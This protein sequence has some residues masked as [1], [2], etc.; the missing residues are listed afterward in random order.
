MTIGDLLWQY[1]LCRVPEEGL[2]LEEDGLA[3][4]AG[5]LVCRATRLPVHSLLVLAKRAAVAEAQVAAVTRIRPLFGVHALVLLE[6][7]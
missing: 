5:D 6:V 4:Q 1:L 7:S 3:A 2:L